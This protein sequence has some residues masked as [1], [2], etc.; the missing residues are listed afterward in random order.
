MYRVRRRLINFR[1]T[2][3]EFEKLSAVAQAQGARGISDFTRQVLLERINSQAADQAILQEKLREF[4]ERL[5]RLEASVGGLAGA[6]TH[7]GA[8]GA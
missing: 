1:V 5:E 4:E 3:E 2:E 8:G 7:R 6:L